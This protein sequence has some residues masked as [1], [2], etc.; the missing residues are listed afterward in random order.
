MS[1]YEA[2]ML[3]LAFATLVIKVID[4]NNKDKK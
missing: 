2:L 3:S 1:V 4:H